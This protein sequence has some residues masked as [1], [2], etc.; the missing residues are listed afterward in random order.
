M[1]KI[2]TG[3]QMAQIDREAIDKEQIPGEWL[4]ENAGRETARFILEQDLA[5]PGD[6]VILLCGKG[7]NG[8]DGFVVAR[9]LAEQ[10][11][12][13]RIFLFG[14][15][16]ELKADAALNWN[17][18]PAP[19]LESVVPVEPKTE[20]RTPAEVYSNALD[21][22]ALIVDAL[23]GTGFQGQLA[24]HWQKF[25]APLRQY[26]QKT[27][28]VDIASGVDAN[29]GEASPGS[30]IAR[31]TVTMGLPKKGQLVAPGM[32]YTGA[33][34]VV[35]IGIPQ[36]LTRA[37]AKDPA[38]LEA[39]DILP[40]L[41]RRAISAHKGT[42]GRLWIVAGSTGLT[43]AAALCAQAA[44]VGGAGLV[45]LGIPQSLN[46]IL[47]MK[48]TEVMTYPLPETAG[49]G[50]SEAASETVLEFA[51]R[52]SALALG[53]GLGRD[54]STGRLVR[55]LI[56]ALEVPTVLDADGVF[57]AA[58]EPEILKGKGL[59]MTPHPG[60]LAHFLGRSIEEVAQQRWEVARE[61]AETYGMVL[62]LKGAKTVIASPDGELRINPTGNPAMASAGMGDV[63]TG[64]VAAFLA[65]GVPPFQAAQAAVFCHGLAGD[66]CAEE[67][68]YPVVTAQEV[69]DWSREAIR[70][71]WA[72]S[73]ERGPLPFP[74]EGP[75]QSSDGG[76]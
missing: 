36:E 19:V 11:I 30:V 57:A 56:R 1:Y 22:S 62:I 41:P 37:G 5:R 20:Q 50:L 14:S 72:Q 25:L 39:R 27:L 2:V 67:T 28:A 49:G 46:P 29:S 24:P 35:D 44:L 51:Q 52:C 8:G 70:T 59:V 61:T 47:E 3:E 26:P 65:Q 9:I 7:N 31:W 48:L 13:P 63:L 34:Q 43:G 42:A 6:S 60:E 15:P 32:D 66:L 38:L 58:A 45:T 10:G 71:L 40:L 18:L 75:H 21:E 74:Q 55:R 16:D 69:L 4:M 64:L 23:F 12:L 68:G 76:T 17:R 54:P 33:L 73:D 53:P